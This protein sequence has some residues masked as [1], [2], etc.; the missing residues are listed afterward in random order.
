MQEFREGN[1]TLSDRPHKIS[2]QRDRVFVG[3]L[4]VAAC[5]RL[6]MAFSMESLRLR[7]DEMD[8]I[9]TARVLVEEQ[10]FFDMY[11]PPLYPVVQAAFLWCGGDTG[12]IRI[13]QGLL[14][15]LSLVFLYRI[16]FR[17]YGRKPALIATAFCAF[18]PILVEFSCILLSET[19]FIFLFLIALDLL[20]GTLETRRNV[21]WIW[22]GILLALAGLTRSQLITFL[23]II[24]LWIVMERGKRNWMKPCLFLTLSCIVV[25]LPWTI[26]NYRA[27]KA[28]VIVDVLGPM[29][30]LISTVPEVKY[31]DKGTAWKE[32]WTRVDGVRYRLAARRN[33]S[34]TQRRALEIAIG[35]IAADPGGFARKCLWEAGHLW[36][37]DNHLLVHLRNGWYGD[38]AK[39]RVLPVAVVVTI[40]F[41]VWLYLSGFAGF[42]FAGRSPFRHLAIWAVV[43]ALLLYGLIYS[44]AR[45][46]VPLRPLLAVMAGSAWS[47]GIRDGLELTSRKVRLLK[48]CA[49]TVIFLLIL[50]V[51][52]REL[53]FVWDLIMHGGETFMKPEHLLLN[54]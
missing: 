16:A 13:F 45:Y 33:T 43:Q 12:S 1:T 18:D 48:I 30:L 41:T 52:A 39:K 14:S 38:T 8:Y 3:L 10:R 37:L 4:I 23:P 7:G 32:S 51:W 25:I 34:R 31:I 44:M 36:T 11:R 26:R 21:L 24:C 5:I 46:A 49:I 40:G 15:A 47:G 54:Q 2:W 9:H 53:P 29:N 42:V 20:T 19:V 17:A 28:V 50:L 22:P 27:S 35:R 6:V